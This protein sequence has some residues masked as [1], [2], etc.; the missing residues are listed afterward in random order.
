M[1]PECSFTLRNGKKCRGTA[2]RNHQFC[3]HHAPRSVYTPPA[4]AQRAIYTP[5]ARWR[6]LGRQ[7][8][9]LGPS[10]IPFAV[11]EILESLTGQN[12]SGH[13]SDAVAGRYLRLLLA[14][15]GHVPFPMPQDE[16]PAPPP[17]PRIPARPSIPSPSNLPPEVQDALRAVKS[18]PEPRAF[19]D[20]ARAIVRSG[21]PADQL[22]PFI[23]QGAAR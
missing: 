23:A 22:L 19:D 8:S 3:R 21:M 20:L 9:T 18:H 6:A 2:I 10:E 14:R 7:V 5:L 13:H 1:S 4:I 17:A 15:L 11:Y 12:P 16:P